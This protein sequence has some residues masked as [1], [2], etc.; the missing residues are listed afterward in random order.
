MSDDRLALLREWSRRGGEASAKPAKVGDVEYASQNE[1]ARTFNVSAHTVGRLARQGRLDELLDPHR[2]VGWTG[3]PI[4]VFGI[5]YPS[6]GAVAKKFNVTAS[7][8]SYHRKRGDL[9]GYLR[10]LEERRANPPALPPAAT[11]PVVPPSLVTP[12]PEP[13][14]PDYDD[15]GNLTPEAYAERLADF[16]QRR[17]R[18]REPSDA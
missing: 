14:N 11:A 2:D 16:R 12:E 5:D 3:K 10:R 18:K 7:T 13:K 15:D 8:I 17:A 4:T 1:I 6:Q 9:E